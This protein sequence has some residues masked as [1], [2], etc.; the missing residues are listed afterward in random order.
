M[1]PI[2]GA[3]GIAFAYYLMQKNRAFLTTG[4]YSGWTKAVPYYALGIFLG[5]CVLAV[6]YKYWAKERYEAIGKFVH[7][8]A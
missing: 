2:I 1:A 7:E 8:E 5:G 3:G 4:E 6:I